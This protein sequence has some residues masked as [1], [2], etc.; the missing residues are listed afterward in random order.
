MQRDLRRRILAKLAA[1]RV[2]LDARGVDP[3]EALGSLLTAAE[4]LPLPSELDGLRAAHARWRA[5]EP[6]G[7]DRAQLL[8]ITDRLRAAL[9]PR[10]RRW[11]AIA[12]GASTGLLA[13]AAVVVVAGYAWHLANRPAPDEGLLGTYWS[14]PGFRGT[15]FQRLDHD[16]VMKWAEKA[17]MLGVPPDRFSV[18]WEGCLVVDEPN[19][20][21]GVASD[22]A[23]R[24]SV[25]GVVVAER[26]QGEQDYRYT[27]SGAPLPRGVQPIRVEYEHYEGPARLRLT[28]LLGRGGRVHEVPS[29]H[30]V[31]PGGNR[32]HPCAAGAAT[33]PR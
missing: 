6:S 17:P 24:V 14:E 4:Q 22:D 29:D 32:R 33:D 8:A 11:R 15:S 1:A 20:W 10:E 9:G 7:L 18:V 30:L 13:A 28:W 5:G 25:G 27:Y 16:L 21:L 23:V 19:R 26:W 12:R 2:L 31:P 3:D